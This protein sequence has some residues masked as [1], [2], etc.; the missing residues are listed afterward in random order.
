MA[1]NN[2]GKIGKNYNRLFARWLCLF[3]N[4]DDSPAFTFGGIP[5]DD[6]EP[7]RLA[8]ANSGTF[9]TKMNYRVSSLIA[10][11]LPA[12]V[13]LPL[14][15]HCQNRG[16]A[17]STLATDQPCESAS[18]EKFKRYDCRPSSWYRL[19]LLQTCHSNGLRDD[20]RTKSLGTSNR[21][22]DGRHLEPRLW[23]S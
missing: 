21:R 15:V 22:N 5:S 16:T 9:K 12:N 10:V 13:L 19:P 2:C 23:Q 14:T 6:E 7:E 17:F 4:N 1:S 20:R 3:P 18:E 8:I 11:R